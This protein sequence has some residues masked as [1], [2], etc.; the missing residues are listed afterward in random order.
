MGNKPRIALSSVLALLVLIPSYVIAGCYQPLQFSSPRVYMGVGAGSGKIFY[1]GGFFGNGTSSP[2]V[3]ILDPSS[4]KFLS[5]KLQLPVGRANI[6]ISSVG[7]KV[8]F[9]GGQFS[10]GSRA[11]YDKVDVYDTQTQ[12][13]QTMAFNV[14]F[15]TF[16][17]NSVV[18]GSRVFLYSSD[19][20]TVYVVDPI[21]NTI[22]SLTLLMA[23]F[24]AAAGAGRVFFAVML[25]NRLRIDILNLGNMTWSDPVY[26][27][28]HTN[29]I[30]GLVSF[31]TSLAVISYTT[32]LNVDVDNPN[33]QIYQTT[34]S[35][36][37]IAAYTLVGEELYIIGPGFITV[38]RPYARVLRFRSSNL[39]FS[40][41]RSTEYNGI[42][43]YTGGF[44]NIFNE[45]VLQLDTRAFLHTVQFA[46]E[47]LDGFDTYAAHGYAFGF[48]TRF[49]KIYYLNLHTGQKY[50]YTHP[51]PYV[52]YQG[53]VVQTRRKVFL[54]SREADG[55]M[56]FDA[57]TA[58]WAIISVPE[59][60]RQSSIIS[61]DDYVV[62]RNSTDTFV[63]N[64]ATNEWAS[65]PV[66]GNH[67]ILIVQ[68]N[69]VLLEDATMKIYNI[70]THQWSTGLH[71][72]PPARFG[73]IAVHN[74]TVLTRAIGWSDR[75]IH[76]YDVMTH[77]HRV[78]Q[79]DARVNMMALVY[80]DY[81]I[82]TGGILIS[83]GNDLS[84]R[85]DIYNAKTATWK[86]TNLPPNLSFYVPPRVAMAARGKQVFVARE[87]RVDV[88]DLETTSVRAI[89]I[90][91]SDPI[92]VQAIGSK[93][94][95]YS[96]RN[97]EHVVSVY[98]TTA[99]TGF[100]FTF[101]GAGD[102]TFMT[103]ENF[104]LAS[105]FGNVKVMELST[106][107]N[108]L[109]DVQRFIGEDVELTV[110]VKGKVLETYWQRGSERLANESEF[111]LSLHRVTQ[112]ASGT[113]SIQLLDQCS[114]RMAEYATLVVHGPPVITLPLE[115]SLVMCHQTSAISI[116][117]SGQ[118]MTFNWLF[119]NE[120]IGT[121]NQ[122]IMLS[123][124]SFPCNS[125][126][127]LC[128]VA[129]NPSGST[130]SCNTILVV[131]H[132][133]VF[134][135]PR[136]VTPQ[137]I[138]LSE[139]EVTL[140]VQLVHEDCT[141]HEW[142]KNGVPMD[143]WGKDSSDI[144]VTIEP[145][146]T[147]TEFTVVAQCGNSRLESHPFKFTSV[148]SWTVVAVVF[149]VIGAT[150]GLVALGV[151]SFF[152]RRRMIAS[153]VHEVELENLLTQAKS[154][155]LNLEGV[156]IVQSTTWE[157]SP[158][159]G[160]TY[161]SLDKMPFVIDSSSLTAL[162]KESV[163]VGVWNQSIIA[164]TLRDYKPSLSKGGMRER[165]I[166]STHIDIYAPRSPKYKIKIEP[167]SV[168]LDARSVAHVTIS[169]MMRMTSKCKIR[170]IVVSEHDKI[171][172]VIE[173]KMSSGM[174]TW[175]DLDEVESNGEYLGGGGFGAVTLGTYRGQEVAVKKLLSQYLT[176]EM[177]IE[178]EREVTLMKDLR[179]PNIV[180][181]V[182]A[183]NV[184]NNLAI[185]IEFAPLGSIAS[186]MEKQKL[187]VAM[188]ITMLLET[189]KALQFLHTNGIIHRD[190]KPQNILVF[191][192]EPRAPVHVKLTDFGTARFISDDPT[193]ITKNI[194]TIAFMAPEAL[195]KNPRIE[196]SA[197]VY[198]FAVLAW[199]MMCEQT[200]FSEFKWDSDIENHVKTGKRL[201][202]L[203]E[204]SISSATIKLI[205]DCWQHEPSQR[206]SMASVVQR[207]AAMN[208]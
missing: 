195:G 66:R 181:F 15:P 9:A 203:D 161:K 24:S 93:I 204:G 58:T 133:S 32:V 137:S 119:G 155:T 173:F 4:G 63:L 46:D 110:E 118:Q 20:R 97:V 185:V 162:G 202:F 2:T 182:G 91:Q 78:E 142:L 44:S 188:K 207:L 50:L 5:T 103:T 200:P 108:T 72:N 174:S 135:G 122:S 136:P 34:V 29:H 127:E 125:G 68:D 168:E 25:Q 147:T 8:L 42:I 170:L 83:G 3:D 6:A 57:D 166:A 11:G 157:W 191:S 74:S 22:E 12:L 56:M 21:S 35:E 196:K 189:A 62:R 80:E 114:Q 48:Q 94:V 7:S 43:Y 198:S 71:F 59:I 184:K 152:V 190:I 40:S 139:S 37:N 95:F 89:L 77:E 145:L 88:I 23:P 143:V 47:A 104:I 38:Y 36:R 26:F 109:S 124:E 82:M 1:A 158:S 100:S 14:T 129:S 156:P 85:V 86:R 113:Y 96:S 132:D 183:S 52:F 102:T 81:V 160:F 70:K 31:P 65:F 138:W 55:N 123:G 115:E 54:F 208:Q 175:I 172:S 67:P 120:R 117:A 64:V 179:H 87:N 16:E 150:L 60:E 197:D 149:T 79:F 76:L 171:Y 201:P 164:V 13:M 49:G 112:A 121:S 27:A 176:D 177:K 153:Q 105:M 98:E 192:L 199:S 73:V 128:V 134:D 186:I 33:R 141:E 17:I 163:K 151:V 159:D 144:R 51:R 90:P 18:A 165:L 19:S 146:I 130:M 167:A 28:W 99:D 111:S 206:P 187:S 148:S 45:R 30:I 101:E 180:Q 193:T 126:H 169:T 53:G 107:M 194:G 92:S 154:E 178:F 69:L 10:F 106:V 84:G 39:F 205:E 41:A 140:T 131:D 75:E 61:S 116:E